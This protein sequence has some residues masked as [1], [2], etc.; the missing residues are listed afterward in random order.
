MKEVYVRENECSKVKL[1]KGWSKITCRFGEKG[2]SVGRKELEEG[3]RDGEGQ[4]SKVSK[5]RDES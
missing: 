4:E 3:E 1:G 5:I 2:K